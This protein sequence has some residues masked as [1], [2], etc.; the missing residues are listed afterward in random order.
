MLGL[1]SSTA[2]RGVQGL[3]QC[4][5][6]GG[7]A[8]QQQQREQQL[9]VDTAQTWIAHFGKHKSH[10]RNC[11]AHAGWESLAGSQCVAGRARSGGVESDG[12]GTSSAGGLECKW[13]AHQT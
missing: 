12:P 1:P 13:G 9:R 11:F 5:A 10:T 3:A 6:R 8:M 7:A 2:V 4:S